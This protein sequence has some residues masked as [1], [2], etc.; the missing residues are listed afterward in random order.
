MSPDGRQLLST[1]GHKGIVAMVVEG[2]EPRSLYRLKEGE[3][4][5]SPR[6]PPTWAADGRYVIFGKRPLNELWCVSA[7]G[8]EAWKLLTMDGT[9]SCVSVHPDGRRIAFTMTGRREGGTWAMDNFLPKP[10]AGE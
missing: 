10:K 6:C 4:T 8:G 2:G 1:Q 3:S 7:E 5:F 9:V